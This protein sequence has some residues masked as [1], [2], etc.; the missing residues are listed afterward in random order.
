MENIDKY[1]SNSKQ[2]LA[3]QP[4]Q[5]KLEKFKIWQCQTCG[6]EIGLLG[7]IIEPLLKPF[8]LAHK[9]RF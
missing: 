7:R 1:N 5:I 8:G 4:I 9:H 2:N 3:G 6:E